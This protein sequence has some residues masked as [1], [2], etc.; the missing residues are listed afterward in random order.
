MLYSRLC[1]SRVWWMDGTFSATPSI[2]EQLYTIHV[3]VNGEFQPHLWC[4]LPN[5]QNVTYVRL[6]QLLQAEAIKINRHLNPNVVHIDFELAVIGALRSE[7][8]VE[9]TGCL[10][11][12]SQSIL[13]NMAGNGLQVTYNTNNPQK[14]GK[15]FVV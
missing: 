4:L 14:F 15:L 10:F 7:L 1:D 5:K 12:S 13:R 2:F 9:P 6:F 8:H 11:H 3:K